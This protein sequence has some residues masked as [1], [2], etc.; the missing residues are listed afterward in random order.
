MRVEDIQN[1]A[2]LKT[3]SN[4]QLEELAQDIRDFLLRQVSRTGGHLSSNL[5]IVELTIAMH[6]VFD[7]E[8]DKFIFDVGHQSYVHKILTGRAGKFNTLRQYGGLSG[9]QKREESICD[10]WEAGHSSTSLSAAL[11]MAV[12]RDL[13]HETFDILP[14]IGDG[15]LTGGMAFEALNDIG[16]RQKKIIILFNDNNMSISKN[17]SAMEKRITSLR[18][19]PFYRSLK[20]DLKHQL[21]NKVGSGVLH[22]LT[23]M[24]D[25]LKSEIIDAPLFKEFNLDYIGP[26][27][28]HNIQELISVL[29]M[30]KEH[31]GPIVVH[32]ATQKGKGYLPAVQDKTGAWHGVGPFNLQTGKSLIK[33]PASQLTWSKVISS[34]LIDLAQ[35]DETI[36]ALTPAMAQGS[37]LLEFA[38]RFPERFFDCQIAE[39]HAVTM[40]CGMAQGGLKPFVS[41]YSSFLQRAYDQV[42]H[43][44]ARMDLPVVLG[45]DRAGLVGEDGDTHQGIYDIAFLRTIPN[46]ILSQ[47]KD[48]K[49]AQ[50]L[51][52][53][54][55]AAG[56]PFA[57]RYPKGTV[58]YRKVDTY[59]KIEIGSWTKHGSSTPKQ[60]VIA[61]GPDVD[62]I[63]KKAKENKMEIEVVNA[64]FFKPIDEKMLKEIL[65]S[66]RPVT[67]YETDTSRGGLLD[68]VLE[69]NNTLDT[70]VKINALGIQDHFVPQ[71]SVRILRRKEKIS[72]EDLFEELEEHEADAS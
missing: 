30:A 10:P 70:P 44:L 57:I 61:Y 60:T 27:D 59:E 51:L 2:F 24:R 19:S 45:V 38:N 26:V 43:D 14:V 62:R 1:S 8:K 53:T 39:Q 16:S 17:H 40:A 46:M 56:R 50:N 28:G 41:I 42:I 6:T 63:L 29:K 64:R 4:Q 7:P 13:K 23:S 69:F 58:E 31:H 35:K 37:Q 15:A 21:D 3:L 9:F 33:L 65:L 71:G 32:I 25:T 22:S 47:P 5:G 12:A 55:F 18:T 20:K 49:E 11:G 36:T 68:A 67:V 48:A 66:G 34:T 52:Y 54:A 72:L